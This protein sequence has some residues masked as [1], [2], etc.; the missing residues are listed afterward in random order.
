[1]Y[2]VTWRFRQVTNGLVTHCRCNSIHFRTRLEV[3]LA[4]VSCGLIGYEKS[5][6]PEITRPAVDPSI[7]NRGFSVKRMRTA[8]KASIGGASPKRFGASILLW[9][10]DWCGICNDWASLADRLATML[11]LLYSPSQALSIGA[12]IDFDERSGRGTPY[13]LQQSK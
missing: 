13:L 6:V 10:T 9:S 4:S 5:L 3:G 1:M 8:I 12:L 7:T 2:S 11:L